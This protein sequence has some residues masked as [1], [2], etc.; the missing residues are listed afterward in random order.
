MPNEKT[1]VYNGTATITMK[2]GPVNGVPV[3]ARAMDNNV[4]SIWIDPTKI[5]SHFGN[6][7]IYGTILK[8]VHIVKQQYA[9]RLSYNRFWYFDIE[10]HKLASKV[11]LVAQQQS[12]LFERLQNKPFWIWDIQEH[13]REDIITKGDCCFNHIIGLPEKNGTDKPLYDYQKIIF[14]SLVTSNGNS[15]LNKHL[16]IKKAT[17][18]GISEFVL[19]F[20]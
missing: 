13:K 4:L 14:D 2:N 16:W 9:T 5:D 17:G 1:I 8:A 20:K 18:L 10:V 6:T 3:S 11:N 7:P 19:R 15:S 12:K